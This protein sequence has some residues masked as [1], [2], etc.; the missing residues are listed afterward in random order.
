MLEIRTVVIPGWEG[1]LTGDGRSH[2]RD[3]GNV[4]CLDLDDGYLDTYIYRNISSLICTY[5]I[6]ELYLNL[7]ELRFYWMD[8]VE[9]WHEEH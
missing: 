4:L 1:G 9:Y 8:F 2:H 6:C 7:K 3:D 5:I